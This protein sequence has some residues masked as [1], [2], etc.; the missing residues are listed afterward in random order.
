MPIVHKDKIIGLV[1]LENS[2]ISRAFTLG[3]VATIKTI[4]GQAAISIQNSQLFRNLEQKVADRIQQIRSIMS[5]IKQGIF[6][7]GGDMRIEADYSDHL[8]EIMG[9]QDIAHSDVS[10]FFVN[11]LSLDNDKKSMIR[12][13]INSL[14]GSDSLAFDLNAHVLPAEAEID[15]NGVKK[16]IEIDWAPTLDDS[17]TVRSLLVAVK[18]VTRM[19]DLALEGAKLERE[20]ALLREVIAAPPNSLI[21][22]VHRATECIAR[23]RGELKVFAGAAS[24]RSM[25]I[26]LHTL[27]GQSRLH[28][29]SALSASVHEA[30]EKITAAMNDN[31]PLDIENAGRD[32]DLIEESLNQYVAIFETKLNRSVKKASPE[33]LGLDASVLRRQLESP[34]L[35]KRSKVLK[36]LLVNNFCQDLGETLAGFH[37]E[38]T[39]LAKKLGKEQPEVIVDSPGIWLTPDGKELLSK[40]MPHL[41]GNSMDH[42]IER[43]EDRLKKGKLPHGT[44]SFV[45]KLSGDNLIL[46]Y[47]DDGNGLNLNTIF[48]KSVEKGL[49]RAD[50]NVS[51]EEIASQI[52]SPGFSTAATVSLV[53]GRGIGMDAV[54]TTIEEAGGALKVE[55]GL[56]DSGN[57]PFTIV[58]TLPRQIFVLQPTDSQ[59]TEKLSA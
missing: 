31:S 38:L 18:D 37:G 8:E 55:L 4:S 22:L 46:A 7:I 5:N 29:L 57:V 12:S 39:K 43:A 36:A 23:N 32:L 9:V 10:Q 2:F 50:A 59:T 33:N 27:K 11:R 1:Y 34:S 42:G 56:S 30:E 21:D 3:R 49:L 40:I 6:S 17:D 41:V 48:K 13:V 19:R 51:P 26:N 54:K 20:F 35:S 45:V 15:A 52:F 24:L 14:L 44:V 53:S 16:I 58:M 47:S 25:F 28:D